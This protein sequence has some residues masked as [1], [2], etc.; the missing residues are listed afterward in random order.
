MSLPSCIEIESKKFN[1]F[2][3]HVNLNL[4]AKSSSQTLF[5]C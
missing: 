3:I 2:S 5:V 4:E 1:C